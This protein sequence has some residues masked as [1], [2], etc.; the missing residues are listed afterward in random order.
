MLVVSADV[1]RDD[2]LKSFV[3]KHPMP[4]P[5]LP[6]NADMREDFGDIHEV[7]VTV[8]IDRKGHIYRRY[9]GAREQPV[10]EQDVQALLEQQTS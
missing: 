10:F 1:G 9:Q 3:A 2:Q 8:L 4:F 5:V 6:A 7:P